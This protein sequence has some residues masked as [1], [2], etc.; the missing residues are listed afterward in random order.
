M[1][2]SVPWLPPL[3]PLWLLDQ[4]YSPGQVAQ[5]LEHH[6]VHQKATGLILSQGTSMFLSPSSFLF[7][8]QIKAYLWVRNFKKEK[9]MVF[10]FPGHTPV[11][12][13]LP[14][15]FMKLKHSSGGVRAQTSEASIP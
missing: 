14:C 15:L 2:L 10:L 5:L 1:T 8:K 6:P 7:P 4:E 9:N 11:P 12:M 13:I 3:L